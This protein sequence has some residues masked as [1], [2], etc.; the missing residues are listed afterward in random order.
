MWLPLQINLFVFMCQAWCRGLSV[1]LILQESRYP[2]IFLYAGK[3][4]SS[5][6]MQGASHFSVEIHVDVK[7]RLFQ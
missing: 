7:Q 4:N 1:Q 3:F 6:K 5:V 2:F